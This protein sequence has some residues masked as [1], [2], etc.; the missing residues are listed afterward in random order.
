MKQNPFLTK[1]TW[2]YDALRIVAAFAVILIHTS[3]QNW[4]STDVH[5]P[6][7]NIFNICDS[8]ARWA[9]PVFTMISGALFLNGNHSLE[10]IYKK[11]MFRIIIAFGFWSLIYG[12]VDYVSTRRGGGKKLF[13]MLWPLSFVVFSHNRR[14]IFNYTMFKKAYGVR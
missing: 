14:P 6:E 4:E 9:V 2:Y 5:S 8:I 13:H 11:N 1:R 7:W 10:K 12:I 3:S